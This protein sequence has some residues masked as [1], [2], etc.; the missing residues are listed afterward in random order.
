[1]QTRLLFILRELADELFIG[2]TADE[3]CIIMF[4]HD[5]SVQPMHHNPFLLSRVND[6]VTT[7]VE[8]DVL[9]YAGIVVDILG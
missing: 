1:M 7:F 3:E 8:A 5:V 9:P 6:A 2:Q 4:C